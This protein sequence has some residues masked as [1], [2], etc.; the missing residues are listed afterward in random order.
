[1]ANNKITSMP[2]LPI[3]DC[4]KKA[5][6]GCYLRTNVVLENN[7]IYS[8]CRRPEHNKAILNMTLPRMS[9]FCATNM[10]RV[11][12]KFNTNSFFH[13][14]VEKPV[15]EKPIIRVNYT[16][17]G[18]DLFIVTGEPKPKVSVGKVSVGIRFVPKYQ[19][20]GK[21]TN[22]IIE[23]RYVAENMFGKTDHI[24]QFGNKTFCQYHVINEN[25]I[26]SDN[27]LRSKQK[28]INQKLHV[29]SK[30][31]NKTLSVANENENGSFSRPRESHSYWEH[32]NKSLPL[33]SM[34]T[35]CFL[36]FIP[37]LIILVFVIDNCIRSDV[38]INED[39]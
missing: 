22:N 39:K 28:F 37:A 20:Q 9:V 6:H 10:L 16:N 26:L 23:I 32:Q 33:W 11:C 7:N 34:V 36:S 30:K 29:S 1:M 19:K 12:P 4:R 25:N 18:L 14:Y 15:C 38:I 31:Q 21:Q 8:E 17:K 24:I 27:T 5:S 35:F 3:K 2:P 13:T